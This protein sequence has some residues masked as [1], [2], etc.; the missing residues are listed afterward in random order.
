MSEKYAVE[1]GDVQETLLLPLW[2][3][4]IESQKEKPL[5]IDQAAKEIID[6]IDYDFSANME[7]LSELSQLGWVIRSLLIDKIVKRHIAKYPQ[8]TIVNIGC[9]FDTTFE[10]VDNGTIDWYDLDLPD[11]IEFRKKF[12]QENDRR[13][14]IASSFLDYE[15]FNQL[16]KTENILFIAAG[17]L[18]YFTE[19]EVKGFI[20]K[21]ADSYPGGEIVFDAT[22][23]LGIKMANKMVLKKSG[24]DEK[25]FLKW[26]LKSAK[27]ILQWDSR[28]ELMGEFPLFKDARKH[29]SAKSK[30]GTFMS[31]VFKAQY[32]VHLRMGKRQNYPGEE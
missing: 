27:E 7:N 25:L 26:G 9:G 3:R 15:W 2:G 13:R 17:L 21:L 30:I 14:F 8:A 11:V 22:S 18:Y 6:R 24:M 28:V 1:L 12:I 19:Y 10:R 29:L 23:P 20:N 16:K 32:L 31:D 4:A 5:L